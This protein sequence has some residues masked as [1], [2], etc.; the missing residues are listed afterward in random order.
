[1]KIIKIYN[2]LY[3]ANKIL[4]SIPDDFQESEIFITFRNLADSF[5]NV[6]N[7]SDF[8]NNLPYVVAV[9]DYDQTV[10]IYGM[11]KLEKNIEKYN[12]SVSTKCYLFT[13]E[14]I[15]KFKLSL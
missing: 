12:H 7:I 1:M 2:D 8:G 14:D 11:N 9:T 3:D 6:K 10:I 5:L 4:Q 13:F 15:E